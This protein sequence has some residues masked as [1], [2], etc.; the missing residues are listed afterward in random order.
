MNSKLK[1]QDSKLGI[2]IAA[3]AIEYADQRVPYR[4][5]GMT[6]RGCD[7]TGLPIAICRELGFL[8]EFVLRQ[9]SSDWNLHAGAGN[10]VVEELGKFGVEIP[11]RQAAVG[12]IAVMLF[13]K[14]PAHC[15]IIISPDLIFV[16]SLKT[17]KCCKKSVLKNS[18]WS[19]RWVKTFRLIEEKLR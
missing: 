5:R 17:N 11:N 14:C 4:H 18:V 3:L 15:G 6:R 9:Y 8:R 1:T 12:D 10:Q 16:H 13:G 7:C 19:S 2:K